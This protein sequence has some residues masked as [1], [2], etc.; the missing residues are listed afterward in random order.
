M[1]ILC[2]IV[3]TNWTYTCSN[4]NQ[5][6]DI[7]RQCHI[8]AS[9]FSCI[10][11]HFYAVFTTRSRHSITAPWNGCK[12]NIFNNIGFIHCYIKANIASRRILPQYVSTILPL[13]SGIRTPNIKTAVSYPFLDRIGIIDRSTCTDNVRI[14]VIWA[15]RI[16]NTIWFI[17][18]ITVC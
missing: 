12:S 17:V 6:I 9:R 4:L 15:I 2:P 11:G 10:K 8:S 7:I 18:I 3:I 1:I 13:H 14:N 16:L 5:I